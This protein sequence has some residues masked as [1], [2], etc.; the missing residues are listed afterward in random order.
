MTPDRIT[1]LRKA[2]G[3]SQS[4][5]ASAIGYSQTY[6]S[7]LEKGQKAIKPRFWTRVTQT[8]N[9]NPVGLETGGGDVFLASEEE[10]G[11]EQFRRLLIAKIKALPPEAQEMILELCQQIAAELS[12]PNQPPPE[13]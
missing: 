1:A 6:V 9:V 11:E 7:S 10:K 13:P 5:F 3:I 2:L 12:A 4:A 8:F